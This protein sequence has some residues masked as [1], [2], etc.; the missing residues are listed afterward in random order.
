MSVPPGSV[1]PFRLQQTGIIRAPSHTM[2]TLTRTMLAAFFTCRCGSINHEVSYNTPD[3]CT[4]ISAFSGQVSARGYH[5]LLYQPS[6]SMD[7]E[8]M[9]LDHCCG[10]L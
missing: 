9:A 2:G 1:A 4:D 7:L 10:M 6:V 5:V 3:P 8:A